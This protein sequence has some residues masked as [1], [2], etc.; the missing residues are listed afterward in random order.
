LPAATQLLELAQATARMLVACV[1]LSDDGLPGTPSVIGI[2]MMLPPV[3]VPTAKH[4]LVA[5]QATAS[6][7]PGTVTGGP[8]TPLVMGTI[9]LGSAP[10]FGEVYVSPTARQVL[11]AACPADRGG[12]VAQATSL[13]KT[14][15]T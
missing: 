3:D 5:G 6:I 9:K 8:G 14:P 12:L 7:D 10:T 13:M 11:A 1:P 2:A 4:L 15:A